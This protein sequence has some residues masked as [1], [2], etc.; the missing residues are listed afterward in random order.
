V[1]TSSDAR[2]L[3]RLL[4][5]VLYRDNCQNPSRIGSILLAFLRKYMRPGISF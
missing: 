1:Q 2:A 5:G 3:E 4:L